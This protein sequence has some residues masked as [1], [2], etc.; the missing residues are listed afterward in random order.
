MIIVRYFVKET[1][2]SQL[3][4][5]FILLVIFFSQKL[6]RILAS[7]TKDDLPI[8]LIFPILGLGLAQMAQ[9]ILPLSLFLAVLLTFGRLYNESEMTAFFACGGSKR[10][11][12]R[13]VFWLV[14]LT[15]AVS[16]LNNNYW[17]P[18]SSQ[19]EEKLLAE[20]KANPSLAGMLDGQFQELQNGKTVLYIDDASKQKFERVFVAQFSDANPQRPAITLADKGNIKQDAK[21]NQTIYLD[22][23]LMY[24]VSNDQK[25]YREAEL[26]D[27]QAIIEYKEA[28]LS[29]NQEF[30]N[31]TI[32]QLLAKS[33][34]I[35]AKTE[36]N[37]R[38]T[39]LFSVPL[40]AFL[41]IPLSQSNPRQGQVANYLP[42]LFIYLIFY[43]LQTSI[44]S[45]GEKGH[46]DPTYFMWLVNLGYLIFAIILNSWDSL[47]MRKLRDKF[48]RR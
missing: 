6:V 43:L 10:A 3:A 48:G 25:S 15:S 20:A 24:D 1:L 32:T 13:A 14:I 5:L 11:L 30:E 21:G 37:W 46:F 36:L 44:K 26:T 23:A 34:S 41:V 12:Y 40:M 38:L 39:L 33:D 16:W 19:M 28:D 9:L 42:V 8:D 47:F 27:Y 31:Y 4:I 29:H 35:Q 17:V 18:S 7:A 45:N 22:H 2:K